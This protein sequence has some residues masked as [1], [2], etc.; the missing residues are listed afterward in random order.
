MF[1]KKKKDDSDN[2]EKLFDTKLKISTTGRDDTQADE[3]HHPYEPT[4]YKV[5]ERLIESGYMN[6]QNQVIDYG[7]GKGRVGFFL[8]HQTKAKTIGIEYDSRIYQD[9][10]EN[11]KTAVSKA[12]AEFLL[13]SAEEYPVP[14]IKLGVY[15]K[16]GH[17]GP[18]VK[19]LDE[20]GLRAVNIVEKA[21]KAIS[22]KK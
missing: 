17:S 22:M 8:S 9:A 4:P 12:K 5:L 11:Q 16:F 10:L 15:D 13:T 3:H 1:G 14:V 21:K 2:Y 7:C 6:A 20:F 18:A 19:L